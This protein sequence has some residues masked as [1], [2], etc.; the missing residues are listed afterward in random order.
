MQ[1]RPAFKQERVFRQAHWLATSS[2]VTLGRHTLTGMLAAGGRQ[3]EDWSCA[4]RLFSQERIDRQALFAPAIK[5]VSEQL[6][7]DE[8]MVVLMDDTLVRKRGR[9]V[10]GAGWKRDP[11][12]P[13]FQTNLV[14]GQRYLQLSAALP[15][16]QVLGRARAVPIDFIHTP[17]PQRPHKTAPAEDWQ[18]FREQQAHMKLSAVAARRFHALRG[19]VPDKRLLC[20]VDGGYTNSAMF[21]AIPDNS[22]LIGRIRKDARLFSV[23]ADEGMRRGR[24][25]Y[26]GKPLPTPQQIRQDESIPWQQVEA[27]AAGKRHVFDVK[28]VAPLRWRGSGARDVRLVVIR[29]LA[30]RPS[31]GVKLLYRDPAYLICSDVNLPLD[32]LL[33]AYL[34]RWEIEVNFRDEKTVLGIGEAQVRLP[35]SVE[36]LPALLVAAFA[37]LLLADAAAHPHCFPSPKWYPRNPTDRPS[38]QHLLALFRSQLWHLAI[39]PIKT[40]FALS[41]PLSPNYFFSPNSIA[42]AICYAFK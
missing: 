9:K 30:Y 2:L 23:P 29:P 27:Y 11:L 12:G 13:P 19:Q 18:A 8:P 22:V 40:N 37:F 28:T 6:G 36:N 33:Q 1:T 10:A 16:R 17:C 35:S 42:S 25:R 32:M 15:D 31:K 7:D 3:F 21:R 26:Y 34:W 4:Y 14:W 38:A 5:G 20:S 39:P 41:P 24:K